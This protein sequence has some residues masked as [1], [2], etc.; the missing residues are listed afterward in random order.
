M[1][2]SRVNAE[3]YRDPAAGAVVE[4]VEREE[5]AAVKAA[6]PYRPLVYICSPYAGDTAKN[7]ENARRYSRYALEQ[8]VIPV[9]VQLLFP[10]FMD[11]KIERQLA[12]K[13]GMVILE[14]CRQVWVFGNVITAGMDAEIKR[15]EKLKKKVRYFSEGR[16]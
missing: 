9:A 8:G 10:Q 15:A 11:E 4:K 2:G 14:K 13:M 6:A 3:G 7:T 1:P 16:K 12:L 5:R